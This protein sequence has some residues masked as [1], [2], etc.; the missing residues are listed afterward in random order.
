MATKLLQQIIER[1]QAVIE[2]SSTGLSDE[3]TPMANDRWQLIT[4]FT[5][6]DS[7]LSD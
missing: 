6:I 2:I 7:Q 5:Y 1:G 3:G 4:N